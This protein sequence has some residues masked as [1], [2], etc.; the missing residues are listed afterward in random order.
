VERETEKQNPIFSE[1]DWEAIRKW[2]EFIT[3][4]RKFYGV[5]Q[6]ERKPKDGDGE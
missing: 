1:E 6:Y 5:K 2:D 3:P 4:I